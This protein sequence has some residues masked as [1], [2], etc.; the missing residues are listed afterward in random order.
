PLFD[1]V[2][3]YLMTTISRACPR[4]QREAI[5]DGAAKWGARRKSL[6]AAQC[7]ARATSA[8]RMTRL[9]TLQT[10]RFRIQAPAKSF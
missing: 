4:S 10:A 9:A 3:Q 2:A 1:V 5:G 6:Y 7:M 8:K